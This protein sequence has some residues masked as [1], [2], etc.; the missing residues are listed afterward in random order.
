VE[1]VVKHRRGF[2]AKRWW[3]VSRWLG[4]R[5]SIKKNGIDPDFI[6]FMWVDSFRIQHLGPISHR[7]ALAIVRLAITRPWF[8]LYFHPTHIRQR[9]N[10]SDCL[11][12][13]T[14]SIFGLS[15]CV[16][17]GVLDE[18]VADQLSG[19]TKKPVLVFPDFF[20]EPQNVDRELFAKISRLAGE[21][22]IVGLLGSIQRRKGVLDLIKVSEALDINEFFFVIAG[23]LDRDSFSPDEL[24]IVEH[25]FSYPPENFFASEGWL[26]NEAFGG[27][28]SC[29]NVVFA[30]YKD[31]PHS[32]S[33]LT[34]AASRPIPVLVSAGYC[35]G[36][37][38]EKWRLGLTVPEGD[39]DK[40][41]DALLSLVEFTVPDK[42][43]EAYLK[44][45]S[46]TLLPDRL[47]KALSLSPEK[48]R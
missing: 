2:R 15:K 36:E 32:S 45:M 19:A 44:I 26:T 20:Q 21:R 42:K 23:K 25:V 38:V 41:R 8:G 11:A 48:V 30:A 6:F 18:G 43:A 12:R 37:R 24:E 39:I 17:I 5:A 27:I 9:K 34:A 28:L 7:L 35:M 14:D 4:V 29:L 40:I 16:G 46:N 13:R 33:I 31:F 47:E 10:Q 1:V 3:P 22:V